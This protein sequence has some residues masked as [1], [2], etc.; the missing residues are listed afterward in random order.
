MICKDD[1]ADEEEDED[2]NKS[3]TVKVEKMSNDALDNEESHTIIES[4]VYAATEEIVHLDCVLLDKDP[5]IVLPPPVERRINNGRNPQ[6]R[7]RGNGNND[8]D[9]TPKSN[10]E[11]ETEMCLDFCCHCLNLVV[12]NEEYGTVYSLM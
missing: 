9:E 3:G 4:L 7:N 6:K 10:G 2:C 12:N 5:I 8:G 1:D 11:Q